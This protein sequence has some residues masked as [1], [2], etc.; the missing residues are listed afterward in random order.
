MKNHEINE[1]SRTFFLQLGKDI[2]HENKELANQKGRV[3]TYTFVNYQYIYF[4]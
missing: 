3:G 2:D 4:P 1:K